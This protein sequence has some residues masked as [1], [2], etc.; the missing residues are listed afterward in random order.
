MEGVLSK[1]PNKGY[2]IGVLVAPK[3]SKTIENDAQN[4]KFEIVVTTEIIMVSKILNYIN[5]SSTVRLLN[6]GKKELQKKIEDLEIRIK[7]FEKLRR[8]EIQDL[9]TRIQGLEAQNQKLLSLLY[10]I[11]LTIIYITYS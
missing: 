7:E 5:T 4:S 10:L 3:F 9:K 11:L 2:I 8:N 1:F 6:L